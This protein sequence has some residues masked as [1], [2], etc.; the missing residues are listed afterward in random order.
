[1][2]RIRS[3]NL[4]FRQSVSLRSEKDTY[5]DWRLEGGPPKFEHSRRQVRGGRGLYAMIGMRAPQRV[6]NDFASS[7]CVRALTEW[8]ARPVP[9][10]M[11]SLRAKQG[12][13]ISLRRLIRSNRGRGNGV[14][15]KSRLRRALSLKT[16]ET[17][18][19]CLGETFSCY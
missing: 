14:V 16:C 13:V 18:P 11:A 12:D 1:M 2:G 3:F 8:S 10:T 6:L 4:S 9:K 19:G 15:E 17:M 5:R 7:R